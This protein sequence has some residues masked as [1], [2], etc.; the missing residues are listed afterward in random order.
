M[1]LSKLATVLATFLAAPLAANPTPEPLEVVISSG[2]D[3]M[4]PCDPCDPCKVFLHFEG[5][6]DISANVD[7]DSVDIDCW[8]C[9]SHLSP[10][11][12]LR[13]LTSRVLNPLPNKHSFSGYFSNPYCYAHHLFNSSSLCPSSHAHIPT[14][15]SITYR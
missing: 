5:Y 1:K 2:S 11:S 6:L 13:Q 14:I 7:G 12:R 10:P 15:I 3:A 9:P 4:Y 8:S